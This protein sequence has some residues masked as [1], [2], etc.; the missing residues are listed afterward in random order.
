MLD[1]SRKDRDKDKF[2]LFCFV[3]NYASF[4]LIKVELSFPD[5]GKKMEVFQFLKI[6]EV[7]TSLPDRP[8]ARLQDF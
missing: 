5:I 7:G 1:I 8:L 4:D 3:L 6:V 2:G